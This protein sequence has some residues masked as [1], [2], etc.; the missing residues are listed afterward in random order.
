VAIEFFAHYRNKAGARVRELPESFRG[1]R[2]RA[3]VD[4]AGF[5]HTSIREVMASVPAI[6]LL[7]LTRKKVLWRN[8]LADAPALDDSLRVFDDARVR[9]VF[10][11]QWR[12]CA[13]RMQAG[14]AAT[15]LD[16][17]VVRTSKLNSSQLSCRTSH[18]DHLLTTFKH[19]YSVYAVKCGRHWCQ[20]G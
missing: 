18:R 17:S 19:E 11:T 10:P 9:V 5:V 20:C 14:A 4:S 7:S 8:L 15:T 12:C 6:A 1:D 2:D 13:Q 16:A 3:L